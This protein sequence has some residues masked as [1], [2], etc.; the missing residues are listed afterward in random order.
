[1]ALR[2]RLLGGVDVEHDGA[3]VPVESGRVESLLAYLL[4]HRHAPQSRQHLAFLLWPDTSDAQARTNLRHVLHTL[5]RTLPDAD[6]FLDATAR[7]LQ[8]RAGAPWELDVE[9]FD[10]AI[11]AASSSEAIGR[12]V[13]LHEAVTLYR[14]DLV[15]GSYDEWLMAERER[16]RQR[17][18][19]ALDQLVSLHEGLGDVREAITC[20]ERLL[21]ADPLK[22][23]AY[24]ILMRLHDARGDRAQALHVYHECVSTLE[25]ELGVPPSLATTQAYDALLAAAGA[26]D[27][28]VLDRSPS[29]GRADERAQLTG[30]WRSAEAGRASVVLVSGEAG[31]GKSRLVDD[32]RAWCAHEGASTAEARSYAAEGELAYGTVTAWLR[33]P[34]MRESVRRLERDRLTHLVRLLP[35][36]L[37]ELPDLPRREPLSDSDQRHALFDAVAHAILDA[38]RPFLLIAEDAHWS[39][40]ESLQLLHYLVRVANDA[41]LLVVATARREEV[42]PDAPL[43]DLVRGVAALDRLTEIELARLSPA[44]TAVLA[45]RLTGSTL[46]DA[47]VETLWRET[48][49]NPLFIVEALRAGWPDGGAVT[50]KVQSVIESRLAQLSEPSRVLV[51]LVALIGRDFTVGLVVDVGEDDEDTLVR[52]LDELWRRRIIRERGGTAYD[53]SHD[54]IRAVAAAGVSPVRRRHH[55]G[56]I[57]RALERAA[58]NQ[59]GPLSAQIAAHHE[60]AG[61]ASEASEWFARAAETAQ[62]LHANAEAVRLLRRAREL[63][64]TLPDSPE[65][66]R[67]ELAILTALPAPMASVEGYLSRSLAAVH[68]RALGLSGA[69]GTEPGAPLLWSLAFANLVRED[70]ARAERFAGDL[71]DRGERDADDI[72]VVEGACLLGIAEFWQANFEAARRHLDEAVA[73]YRD[74]QRTEHLLRYGQDPGVVALARL[75]NTLWFL[76]DPAGAS[77]CRDA[78][79]ARAEEI[80]HPLTTSAALVFASLL[81]L[82]NGDKARIRDH[83]ESLVALGHDALQIRYVTAAFAGYVDVLDGRVSDGLTRIR[84]AIDEAGP[85]PAAPGMRAV[86]GRVELAAYVAAGDRP[87]AADA[88]KRLLAMDGAARVWAAEARRQLAAFSTSVSDRNA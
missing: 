11:E 74:D 61:E 10:S 19:D 14:G 36:L 2:I 72:L 82:D 38:G 50:P 28:A 27:R 79:L 16:Y 49:G 62:E 64:L 21:A 3:R 40:R 63:L 33:S 26:A 86:F 56:R 29:V 76:G 80:G 45:Q 22:E 70:F 39:D 55:H 37:D 32:F 41:R 81:A 5:R 46:A 75:G 78:A 8:W 12:V 83:A 52:S 23:Q 42:D 24:R 67:R 20:A 15:P 77:R 60:Q 35:E 7:T 54:T 34:A 18:V 66:D 44:D 51:G 30:L 84:R 47:A 68:D 58:G 25:R 53:F 71:R 69:L 43:A 17:Y 1:V 65:R 59:P 9:E 48:E 4:L 31:I 13:R 87:G 57:A 73:R 88:A 6:T 85:E